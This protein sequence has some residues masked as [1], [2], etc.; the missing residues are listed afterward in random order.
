[1]SDTGCLPLQVQGGLKAMLSICLKETYFFIKYS[2]SNFPWKKISLS[3]SLSVLSFMLIHGKG[4]QM[5]VEI[6]LYGVEY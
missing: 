1:M 2:T 3:L 6:K 4:E 5:K